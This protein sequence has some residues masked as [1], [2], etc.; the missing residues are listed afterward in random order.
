[1]KAPCCEKKGLKKWPWTPEEDQVLVSHI[2][3]NGHGNWRALPKQAGKHKFP[4]DSSSVSCCILPLT[5][6]I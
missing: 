4:V 1:M 6:S 3:K 2:Q 5:A